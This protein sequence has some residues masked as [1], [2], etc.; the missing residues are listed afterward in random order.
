MTTTEKP[1]ADAGAS[2]A[3]GND[4]WASEATGNQGENR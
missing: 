3:T 4:A 1:S 2:E